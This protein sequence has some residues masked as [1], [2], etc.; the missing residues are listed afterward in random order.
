MYKL[1][2]PHC[3]AI[4]VV[5]TAKAGDEI[6]CDAC[7]HTIDVPKLGELRQLPAAGETADARVA[8]N[9]AVG[10]SGGR[11]LAFATLGLVGLLALLGAGFCGVNWATSEVPITTE[12]HLELLKEDYAAADSAQMI[13]EFEDITEY[14]VAV[15][16]PL[17]YRTMELEKQAWQQKTLTFAALAAVSLVLAVLVGWRRRGTNA[18]A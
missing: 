6:V 14:G 9:A 18:P 7:Q 16:A 12:G 10:L 13:R 8:A 17:N 1:T 5:S 11:S 3:E 4:H 15:E 2:C